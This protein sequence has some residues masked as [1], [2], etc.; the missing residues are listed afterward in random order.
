M[1][2]L[3]LDG[4]RGQSSWLISVLRVLATLAGVPAGAAC[5]I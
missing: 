3:G 5:Q 4:G 1:C 2:I